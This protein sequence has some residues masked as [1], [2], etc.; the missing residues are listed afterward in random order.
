[1]YFHIYLTDSCNLTCS[2]C[3]G[4]IFDT[5]EPD[6]DTIRIDEKIP[7]DVS[8]DIA[9]LMYFLNQDPSA[10]I[11]FIGGEPTLRAD[12]IIR[13]MSNLPDYRFMLQTNGLLLHRLPPHIVNR[14][15]TILIS[16]DGDSQ[17]TDSGRGPGTYDRIME[18]IGHIL[19]G[20]FTGE[21]IARMTV[22]EKTNI[23]DAVTHLASNT[24]HSF[25]SIHWQIDANFWNDYTVRL[26][27][28][29]AVQSYIP[30]ITRLAET[31]V[32]RMEKTGRVDRWYPFI[33]PIE[34]MLFGR[35]SR[36]RCGSGYTNYTVLTNG[37]ISPC[38]IM[39]GMSDYY[40]GDI[41][42]SDPTRLPEIQVPGRCAT[43]DIRTFCG[44][45]CLYAAIMEPWPDE[46]RVQ[47]CD[48]VRSLKQT[49]ESILPRIISHIDSGRLSIGSFAHEKFNGCEIIP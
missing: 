40:L 16:I 31:W 48:T 26:F 36:L 6:L 23:F 41:T 7:A 24:R 14:F 35:D 38:P 18:N 3:R 42:S 5:P 34:D 8:Y 46:G 1:M 13:I 29:W 30:G 2:Y 12:L 15:E 25:D 33:D 20:G 39:I 11:T 44:G 27:Q 4:K 43:C 28:T 17:I 19:A 45:R 10:V 32:D 22:H 9:D 49:L 47:V 21:I 37:K